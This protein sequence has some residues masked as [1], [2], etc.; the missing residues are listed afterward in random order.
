MTHLAVMAVNC[1]RQ[2]GL[3]SLQLGHNYYV[4]AKH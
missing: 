1:Q 2:T 3:V 4:L